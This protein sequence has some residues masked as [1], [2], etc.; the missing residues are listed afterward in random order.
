M[1]NWQNERLNRRSTETL[2]YANKN[3]RQRCP[4]FFCYGN[5]I[6]SEQSRPY[7]NNRTR[8]SE[9]CDRIGF[10]T[11]DGVSEMKKHSQIRE[12]NRENCFM[13]SM[14]LFLGAYLLTHSLLGTYFNMPSILF[15][16]RKKRDFKLMKS[17]FRYPVLIADEIVKIIIDIF[18]T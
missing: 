14:I 10:I 13:F 16:V 3:A 15:S 9:Q 18:V 2:K 8:L 4:A 11:M 12:C 17:F 7:R 1:T 6:L 5:F